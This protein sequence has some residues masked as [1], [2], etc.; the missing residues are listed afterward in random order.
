MMQ[1]QQVDIL[2]IG[3]G[4]VGLCLTRALAG[5]G[6]TLALVEQHKRSV[7][8]NPAFDGREIAL[9]HA[10]RAILQELGIWQRFDE[11][12]ISPLR[13]A[14]VF[15]GRSP[16]ALEFAAERE[17]V[18]ALGWL[19]PN[20]LIRR[21]AWQAVQ[22]Q[23]QLTLIDGTSVIAIAAG[24]EANQVRLA[25]GRQFSARLVVAADS[26]F[27]TTRRMLGIGAQMRDFGQS[28]LIC[29]MQHEQP[30]H[31]AAWEWFDEERTLALLPLLPHNGQHCASAVMTLEPAQV[32]YLLTLDDHA[33]G[34]AVTDFFSHRLGQMQP[35]GSRHVYP[36]VAVYA[37]HL[38]GPRYALVG[39]AAVGMH[40]VTAH[41]FNFGL[42]S[43]RR[44]AQQVLAAA[45][46]GNDIAAPAVL[47]AY[48]R[49][50]R[51]ATRPLYEATN[52]IASLYS[53][54][55]LPARLLRPAAL[56]LAQAV[57]PFRKLIAAHLTQQRACA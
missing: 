29:R 19:V 27:S 52:S 54:R 30:H 7:L 39:D 16:F 13:S 20:H 12:H 48:Q 57:P 34:A 38:V 49:Q 41:G 3:A 23:G 35:V 43:Q 15:N 42:Q 36:L 47:K 6:L 37:Q 2:I 17:N 4:P 5:S 14:K 51:L 46:Q 9:T 44:L 26:R 24:T 40:P 11:G 33:F 53:H 18:E 45:R 50:H 32:Q 28:M 56:R 21:A 55:H 10:S 25:D 8:E 1:A 22:E 31:H